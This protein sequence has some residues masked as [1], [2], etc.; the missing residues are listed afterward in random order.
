MMLVLE[1][2]Y[3]TAQLRMLGEKLGSL[4]ALLAAEFNKEKDYYQKEGRYQEQME[5]A[6]KHHAVP[7]V[8]VL[9]PPDAP[10]TIFIAEMLRSTNGHLAY[11]RP[12]TEALE[13]LAGGEKLGSLP[14]DAK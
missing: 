10:G 13:K 1:V 8:G 14:K 12:L 9:M 2:A 4:E 6:M 5:D 3:G 7:D 11:L